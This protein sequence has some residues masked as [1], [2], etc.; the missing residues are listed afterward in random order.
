MK[1]SHRICSYVN[2]K[3][4]DMRLLKENTRQ[5]NYELL[6]LI[7]M[8]MVVSLHSFSGF[9]HGSGIWQAFDIFRETAC[10]CAVDV[11]ILISGYFGIRWK[12]K[13]IFNLLF[14]VAFYSFV[15]YGIC[16]LLGSANFTWLDFGS[17][18]KCFYKSWGF[19][20]SYIVLY[21]LSPAL[22]S[23]S[24]QSTA[25]EL[26][27]I[28]LVLL[29]ANIFIMGLN[30]IVTFCVVYLIGRWIKKIDGSNS[31]KIRSGLLYLCTTTV[32]FLVVY[33]LYLLFHLDGVR[34]QSLFIGY[35]YSTPLVIIQAIALLLFFGRL[36]VSNRF[37]TIVNWCSSSCLAIFLIHMHPSVK[38]FYY[39]FTE[40][41][42]DKPIIEHFSILLLL[43]LCV[44][45]VS[46]MFDKLR[47]LIS[48]IVYNMVIRLWDLLPIRLKSFDTYCPDIIKNVL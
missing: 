42:Y 8:L 36:K 15:I 39:K 27:M 35:N 47:I 10:I 9:K 13:S 1:L 48:N 20:S 14:Q 38:G 31:L 29:F 43:F 18:F 33:S 44:F 40:G 37:C 34:M 41:L 19:I 11:F 23:I 28:I 12:I 24:E 30:I 25:K 2:E 4:I 3:A 7:S 22:N 46:I 17:N 16:I 6:R 21:F 26:M 5:S 45:V 32:I